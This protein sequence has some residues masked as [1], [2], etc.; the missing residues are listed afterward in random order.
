[1][2]A[3]AWWMPKS[4]VRTVWERI[5]EALAEAGL[6]PTQ[7]QAARI[8]NIEQG[9]VS[10]WNRG[11]YPELDNA[12]ALALRLNVCVEWIYTERPPKRPG[13]PSDPIALELWDYWPRLDEA[14]KNQLLG[15][16][17]I[18]AKPPFKRIAGN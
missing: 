17:K 12:L 1:M 16:A 8:C 6:P 9:S 14:H 10:D 15:A 18:N 7:K 3:H 4:Q 5:R 13:P 11:G 2:A